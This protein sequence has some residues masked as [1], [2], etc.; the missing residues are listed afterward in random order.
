MSKK[1]VALREKRAEKFR[2]LAALAEAETFTDETAQQV[3]ALKDEIKGIDAQLA[4]IQDVLDSTAADLPDN[5]SITGGE[6]AVNGDS[7]RGYNA[8]A[9]FAQDVKN[10]VLTG[11]AP[12]RLR[13]AAASTVATEGVGADGGY[14]I[15]PEYSSQLMKLVEDEDE[16]MGRCNQATTTSNSM[17]FPKDETTQ[18]GTDGIQAYWENEAAAIAQ[19]KPGFK[20]ETQRLKKLT[21]LVP[22]TEEL[23]SDA[24]SL[25][26]Y[27]RQT[28]PSK[29]AF[30]VSLAILQGSGIGQPLGILNSPALKTVAKVTDQTADTIN[31][32]NISAMWS[33]MLAQHRRNAIWLVNQDAEPQ[34]DALKIEGAASGVFPAYLPAGGISAS[35]Y[36]TL[37]GKP[38]IFTQACETVGDLGDILFVNLDQYRILRKA[39]GMQVDTSMHLWFDQALQAFRFILR[40]DGQPMLSAPIAA[41]DGS[42]TYSPF[43]ALAAR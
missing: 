15:P 10:A 39:S 6:L 16:L 37:K 18:W 19:S 5:A 43:V 23:L 24:P 27:I 25:D 38:V 4:L 30:K 41:R 17:T 9:H 13:N 21:A 29:M 35:P 32:T 1:I 14:L 34:L 12:E 28:A 40:L 26:S 36:S 33:G 2:N 7:K 31:F 3:K 8:F 22:V 11:N 20:T 42:A